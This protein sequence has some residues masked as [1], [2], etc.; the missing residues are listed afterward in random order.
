[1]G[2]I[3]SQSQNMTKMKTLQ[4]EREEYK[5]AHD[6]QAAELT[7]HREELNRAQ[8]T[9]YDYAQKLSGMDALVARLKA[10]VVQLA[11]KAG[12]IQ[13]SDDIPAMQLCTPPAS[14]DR[15]HE[16]CES[17]ASKT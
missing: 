2:P 10:R 11:P 5:D 16:A 8:I 12:P 4:Q 14:P 1:M 3:F 6:R 13:Y 17:S 7:A 15:D 9:L